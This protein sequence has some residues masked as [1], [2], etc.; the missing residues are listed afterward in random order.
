MLQDELK[1]VAA[2][3]AANI[4]PATIAVVKARAGTGEIVV[5][6]RGLWGTYRET[7]V[8][9]GSAKPARVKP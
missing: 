5:V 1:A 9:R 6:L 4:M 3:E 8:I 7:P 2:D